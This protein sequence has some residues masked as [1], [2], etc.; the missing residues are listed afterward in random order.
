MRAQ[1]QAR[2]GQRAAGETGPGQGAGAALHQQRMG[3]AAVAGHLL[4]Q[5]TQPGQ[6][7]HRPAAHG[8]QGLSRTTNSEIDG[9]ATSTTTRIRSL[10]TK[11]ITPR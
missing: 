3:V 2:E 8:A 5:R 1:P 7:Q 4:R 10:A 11:G 9:T 6:R